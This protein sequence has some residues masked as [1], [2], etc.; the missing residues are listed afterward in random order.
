MLTKNGFTLIELLVVVSVIALLL[1]LLLPAL[2]K[3]GDA[4]HIVVCASNQHQILV[5]LTTHASDN[6]GNFPPGSGY[7]LAVPHRVRRGTGDFFDVLVPDYVAPPELWYCPA[8][9]FFADSTM[10]P[11]PLQSTGSETFWDFGFA[12]GQSEPGHALITLPVYVNLIEKGGYKDI[13]TKLSDPG[14]WV[15]VIDGNYYESLNGRYSYTNHPGRA[16]PFGVGRFV[17]GR[18][19]LGA[20]FGVNTGTVDGSVKWTPTGECMLGYPGNDGGLNDLFTRLLEPHRPGRRG[21]FP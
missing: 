2:E 4:A 9:P 13:A 12:C 11:P 19:G 10:P 7:D 8:G 6:E 5:A 3:A 17:M 16:V 21:M 15:V 14:D 18:T 1:A 20:P